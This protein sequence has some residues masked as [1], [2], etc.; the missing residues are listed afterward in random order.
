LE[1]LEFENIERENVL[2]CYLRDWTYGYAQNLSKKEFLTLKTQFEISLSNFIKQKSSELDVDKIVFESMHNF[3]IGNDDRD[4]ARYFI[5]KYFVDFSVPVVYN[6][7]LSTVDS[8]AT[9][10]KQSVHNVVM[11][12]HSVLFADTLQTSY[13]AIDYTLGGKIENYLTDNNRLENLMKITDLIERFN[14]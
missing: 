14:K 9:S 4:F 1:L 5:K 12:F 11:R 10:M 6:K 3:V 8:I 2:R 13:T 7:K